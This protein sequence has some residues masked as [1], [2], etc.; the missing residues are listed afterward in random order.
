MLQNFAVSVVRLFRR[1]HILECSACL[2]CRKR[3]ADQVVNCVLDACSSFLNSEEV[4]VCLCAYIL[5]VKK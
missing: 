2:S 5:S 3:V 4:C 1:E